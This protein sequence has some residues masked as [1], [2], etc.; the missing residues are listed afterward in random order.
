MLSSLLFAALAAFNLTVLPAEGR[1]VVFDDHPDGYTVFDASR[2]ERD[3]DIARVPVIA[4]TGPAANVGRAFALYPQEFDCRNRRT[5]MLRFAIFN[6]D[7]SYAGAQDGS[8]QDW[9]PMAPNA[10]IGEAVAYVCDGKP[11]P[12]GEPNLRTLSQTYWQT[13]NVPAE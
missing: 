2:V 8:S 11:L 7:L 13:R 3:G 10:P 6:E 12:A 9:N 1:F 5:R 4:I